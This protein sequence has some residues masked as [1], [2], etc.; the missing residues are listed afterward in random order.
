[1]SNKVIILI[2]SLIFLSCGFGNNSEN[3][4]TAEP[5][6]D[7]VVEET[8][9]TSTSSTITSTTTTVYVCIP[10]DNSNIDF[11][12]VKSIQNFL[13]RYGYNAGDEDGYLGNQTVS[14][15]KISLNPADFTKV[16]EALEMI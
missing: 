13:N 12:N 4:L 10:E 5:Q 11:D 2:F 14:A 7:N 6:N 9:T 8:T 15:I 3:E 16:K 1:M